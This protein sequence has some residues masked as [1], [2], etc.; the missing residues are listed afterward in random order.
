MWIVAGLLFVQADPPPQP[1]PP[2]EVT[3]VVVKVTSTI[4]R[5]EPRLACLDAVARVQQGD[6]LQ[7]LE[8]QRDWYKAIP[9]SGD[10]TKPGYLHASAVRPPRPLK[11]DEKI[12]EPE[13]EGKHVA[14]ALAVKG[15]DQETEKKFRAQKGLD[16]EYKLLDEVILKTPAFKGDPIEKGRALAEFRRA[17]GLPE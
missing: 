13:T 11:P 15:F 14:A 12:G 3:I 8:R 7:V 2:P 5:A 4:L 16:T 6:K 1:P 17:G 9:P 10:G